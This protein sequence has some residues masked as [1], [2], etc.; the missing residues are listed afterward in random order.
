MRLAWK[1][2]SLIVGFVPVV[3]AMLRPVMMVAAMIV[4][5]MTVK[6]N[7]RP[8]IMSH[9]LSRVRAPMRMPETQTLADQQQWNQQQ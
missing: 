7:M 1:T 5:T 8:S 9:R 2:T 3:V 6:M 4:M